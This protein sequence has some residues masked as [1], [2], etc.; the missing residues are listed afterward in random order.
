MQYEA[1][2]GGPLRITDEDIR[3]AILGGITVKSPQVAA[4][5][6][7]REMLNRFEETPFYGRL[8]MNRLGNVTF[9]ENMT[10]DWDA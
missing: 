7:P 1:D 2:F 6:A 9:Q 8:L 5:L 3:D 4:A 10:G